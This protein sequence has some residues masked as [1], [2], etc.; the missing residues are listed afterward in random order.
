[1]ADGTRTRN[2]FD[3]LSGEPYKLSRSKVE[4]FLQCPRCFYLD[5]R[6]GIN[7]PDG[8]PFTLNVAVDHLLKKEFDVYRARSKPHPLMQTYGVDAVPFMH[9]RLHDWRDMRTG[10]QSVHASGFLV[11]GA[12]DD[13]W[14]DPQGRLIV[15]DY[16]ATSTMGEVTLEG[17][18]KQAYKRQMEIYQWLL[19]RNGFDVGDTGYFVYVNADKDREAFDRK[20]EFT[21]MILPYEGNDSWVDEALHAA[22][23]CLIHDLPP[24]Y[25][26]TCEWC[27]YR[28]AARGIENG[29]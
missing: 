11:F 16:K 21:T 27:A 20:L 17:V 9:P 3:P 28:R 26:E 19:R 10:V 15:V 24:Q 22:H 23:E 29:E 13:V 18:W 1:M 2:L 25:A 5:R 7:R 6:S 14:V 12:V 4:L 8:P